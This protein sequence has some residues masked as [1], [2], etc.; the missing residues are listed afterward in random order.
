MVNG[1]AIPTMLRLFLRIY[2][3]DPFQSVESVLRFCFWFFFI[4]VFS[5]PSVPPW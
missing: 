4:L 3:S 2:P 1:A 5:V